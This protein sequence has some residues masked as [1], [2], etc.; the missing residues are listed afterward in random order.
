MFR[1]VWDREYAKLSSLAEYHRREKTNIDC[2][3]GP[4]PATTEADIVH[5]QTAMGETFTEEE[6]A[7]L[8]DKLPVDYAE[9]LTAISVAMAHLSEA[10][11]C[12]QP[13]RIRASFALLAMGTRVLGMFLES[14]RVL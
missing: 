6:K 7:E 12:K 4:L 11:P 14:K 2:D 13:N 9:A 5:F 10:I 1:D 3:T 8:K